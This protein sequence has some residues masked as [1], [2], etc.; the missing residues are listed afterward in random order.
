MTRAA[1]L[2]ISACVIARDEDDRIDA[3]LASLSFCQERLVV[4]AHSGDAT[5]ERARAAGARVIERDWPGHVAQKE[6]AVRAAR[7]EWVFCVDADECVSDALRHEI[8]ALAASGALA[9]DS[10]R[11]AAY[12]MPRASHYLGRWIRHGAWYPNRQ[13]RLFD[14]RRGHWT[15]MDPHDRVAVDGRVAALA[16][17]LL[18]WPYRNLSEHLD[19]IDRY[20]TLMASGLAERGRR[21]RRRDLVLRPGVRFLRSYVLK[22]GFLDG[23]RGLLIASLAA[24]YGR[25]KYAKLFEL[26]EQER[27]ARERSSDL[28]GSQP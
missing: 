17:E 4:D 27:S 10:A 2:P 16:G 26:Q 12:T 18:H 8:R 3:C 7:C 14:R 15:G 5:R 25:M 20:T 24:H 1:P 23:W 11:P 19:T 22:R 21:A 6:F 28:P 13:L 9:N